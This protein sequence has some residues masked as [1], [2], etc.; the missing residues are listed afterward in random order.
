MTSKKILQRMITS[1]SKVASALDWKMA[2]GASIL[3]MAIQPGRIGLAVASHP[4]LQQQQQ[5]KTLEAI[6]MLSPRH[7]QGIATGGNSSTP[8]EAVKR[9]QE[10]VKTHNICGVVVSWPM[11]QDT[12]KMGYSCGLTLHT[13][14]Q[15]LLLATAD[16]SNPAA[17]N[18]PLLCLWDS[19]H[20]PE[21][22]VD[23]WGRS[24][25]YARTSA[26]TVHLAS[27]EQYYVS[28]TASTSTSS[29]SNDPNKVAMGVMD[30]FLKVNWPTIYQQ[31]QAQ[32]KQTKQQQGLHATSL[33]YWQD[34]EEDVGM[35]QRE[36]A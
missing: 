8:Q 12:G 14:E 22:T 9:L 1:P 5:I 6:T 33:E 11:Q 24:A 28:S 16:A 7:N 2:N 10:I 25:D 20:T 3:S 13:L 23:S 18:I 35:H 4:S 30:D 32:Q 19:A 21:P 36:F 15:L 29:P 17:K 27:E 31:K 34:K 26:K